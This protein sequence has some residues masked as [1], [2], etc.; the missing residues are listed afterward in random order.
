M[1]RCASATPRSI[2]RPAH[3]RH[4]EELVAEREKI[5]VERD[6]Q[7]ADAQRATH[8]R[9]ARAAGARSL[10]AATRQQSSR[11]RG[12]DRRARAPSAQRLERAIAAQE[13]IIAYR[14]SA[15]WWLK[16]PWLRV[17]LPGGSDGAAHDRASTRRRSSIDIV[18][19][20]VQRA[21]RRA[22]VRRERAR[23][24]AARRVGSC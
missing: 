8:E 12:S 4:L 13:R 21:G 1:A 6:A 9:D 24:S 20:G 18:V 17:R 22:R 2:G 11:R 14:Q 5:V 19:A 7:L 23:A 10:A 16:L 15:R 3:V